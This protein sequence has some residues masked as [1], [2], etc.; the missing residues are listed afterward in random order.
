M[1]YLKMI[2]GGTSK[3]RGKVVKIFNV[4]RYWYT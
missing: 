3:Q 1:F 2:N 4:K